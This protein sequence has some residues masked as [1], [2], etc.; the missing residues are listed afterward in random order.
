ML[1]SLAALGTPRWRPLCAVLL[2]AAIYALVPTDSSLLQRATGLERCPNLAK[3]DIGLCVTRAQVTLNTRCR[4]ALTAD[5]IFGADTVRA[6]MQCQQLLGVA[7]DGQ[8]GPMTKAALA[9]Q[10]LQTR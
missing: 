2:L 4:Q 7:A 10:L 9:A 5:G 3:G 8:I 1:W 6:V